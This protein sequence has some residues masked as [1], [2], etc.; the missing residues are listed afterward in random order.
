MPRH[1]VQSKPKSPR[2]GQN[3]RHTSV[4]WYPVKTQIRV[5]DKICRCLAARGLL[6]GLDSDPVS[7]HGVTSRNDAPSPPAPLP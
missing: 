6:L 2:S 1:G 7:W 4:G 3:A 5:A